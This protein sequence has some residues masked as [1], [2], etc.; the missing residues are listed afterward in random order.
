MNKT[1]NKRPI[2]YRIERVILSDVLPYETPIV[3]SNRHFYDILN[4]YEIKFKNGI[5]NWRKCN[6]DEIIK[7]T[8][9]IFFNAKPTGISNQISAKGPRVPFNFKISHKKKKL[10]E[11]SI[12]HPKSQV[13]LV[14]FY[15]EFKDLVLYYCNQSPFSIRK[16]SKVARFTYYDDDKSKEDQGNED[17]FLEESSKEYKNLKHFFTYERYSN[18]Y[19]FYE[20][21]PYHR[22]EKKYDKMFKFDISKCFDS[23]YT[24]SLSWAIYGKENVKKNLG[25]STN[26]FAGKFDEFM[27]NSNYGETNGIVIGPEFSRIFAEIILQ[28][29]DKRAEKKLFKK[30]WVHNKD[31]RMFRYV[32]DFFIFYNRDEAKDDVLEIYEVILNEFKLGFNDAKSKLYE[33][34]L[35]TEITIA[36]NKIVNLLSEKLIFQIKAKEER[37]DKAI[38]VPEGNQP[39]KKILI[40]DIITR[41]DSNKLI[42]ELKTIVAS[43]N[44]KYNDIMNYT[45]VVIHNTFERGLK[46]Y[47]NYK[48]QL[49]IKKHKGELSEGEIVILEKQE[50]KFTKA[51]VQLLD[52][53]F[54]LYNVSPKVNTTVKVVK[55]LALIIETYKKKYRV[56]IEGESKYKLHKQFSEVNKN[57]AF[58]K[59]SDEIT[60]VLN[61]NKVEEYIQVETLYLLISLRELG[62]GY[63]LSVEQIVKY[64]N[65]NKQ[66]G[67]DGEYL[68]P[69]KYKFQSNINY[70]VITVLLFYFRDI[71]AYK[72]LQLTIKELILLRIDKVSIED[73]PSNTEF[74]LL[75]FDLITC[76]Y[77]EEPDNTFKKELI[78]RFGV[79]GDSSEKVIA[80]IKKQKYWFIKWNNFNLLEEINT[81]SNM[82]VYA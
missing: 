64:L 28:S 77:L 12:P 20:D 45:F 73:R 3:F 25:Q 58:K 8:L 42:T 44:V 53:V 10:R 27:M 15:E 37:E 55:T 56:L 22:A 5:I 17:D 34:P 9:S 13:E 24:H 70:F 68:S 49:D 38:E 71:P 16:P 33:K 4:K 47:K 66:K 2:S 7:S 36:K 81:K 80:F 31:Y 61:S 40:S 69:E 57:I 62:K 14:A 39:E 46:K 50:D 54:F 52:F 48:R 29:I 1:R 78:S 75:L 59:I 65:L 63:Q 60:L 82:E 6:Q 35:I 30:G 41:C 23:I 26:T 76:P 72:G 19:K 67:D 11:L 74:I 51:V 43:T 21:Y 18:I 79:K 32:D